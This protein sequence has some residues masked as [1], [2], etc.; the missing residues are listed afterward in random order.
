M[1]FAPLQSSHDWW[2][3]AVIYQIYTRSF[4]D[5]NGDGV[6]DFL[7]VV[8]KLDDLKSLGVDMIW[9]SPFCTSPND[10]N[11]YDVSDY[12]SVNPEFGTLEDL[13]FLIAE[14]RE[15]DMDVMMDLVFNHTSDEHPWFVESRSSKDNPKR[16]WY[17]WAPPKN[18][19]VPN[20]W[21]SYFGGNSW[22]L[23]PHTGEYYLHI[24]SKKQPDLNWS[25]PQVREEMLNIAQFWVDLGI[26]AFRLDAIHL[27][28]K[29]R[30]LPD[31]PAKR[32]L[33]EFPLYKN[34]PETHGYL[35]ELNQ[36]VF[37]PA[38][39]LLV[40][41]TGGTTPQSAR[42]YVDSDRKELDM[43]FHFQHV[44]PKDPRDA[45]ALRRHQTHWYKSLSQ[46]GWDAQ[47]FSNHDLPRQVSVFGEDGPFRVRSAQAIATLLLTS[48]GT[49][50]IYQGEEIGMI[51]PYFSKVADYRDQH[52]LNNYYEALEQGEDKDLAWQFFLARGRD[53]GRTPLPWTP[54]TNGGFTTGEPWMPLGPGY[55]Q[56]NYSTDRAQDVSVWK[57]YQSLITLRK[58]Q[59]VFRRGDWKTLGPEH[60]SLI[61]F[62]RQIRE[63]GKTTTSWVIMNWSRGLHAFKTNGVVRGNKREEYKLIAGN[64]ALDVKPN[65]TPN[66]PL[67]VIGSAPEKEIRLRPWEVRIYLHQS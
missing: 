67:P 6:G 21:R 22:T 3:D 43:I 55:S 47:F 37:E 30:G 25:N 29:P 1:K 23:D 9:L 45:A 57:W 12:T 14:A 18:G 50:F 46:K 52:A 16:D 49:P 58:E 33:L 10:D 65:L 11:G 35:K 8:E 17:H 42:L 56:I 24:F 60:K 66:V 34:I 59:K 2:K 54:E 5:S 53:A 51:N 36:K 39:A 40:G 31:F 28:G 7:G 27:I 64:Y 38:G 4:K 32:Q 26:K 63:G 15:R 62:T 61:V 19:G 48:W 13:K 41:E 44:Y 20:N